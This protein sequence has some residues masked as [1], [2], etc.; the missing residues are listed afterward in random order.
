MR[1]VLS[2][3]EEDF[4]VSGINYAFRF[5]KEEKKKKQNIM[6]SHHLWPERAMRARRTVME[7]KPSQ[8]PF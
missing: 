4:G 8:R 5:Q 1:C 2:F 6:L 7:M 3:S